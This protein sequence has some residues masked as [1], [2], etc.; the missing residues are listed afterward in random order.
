[1]SRTNTVP[2]PYSVCSFLN[3]RYTLSVIKHTAV[4]HLSA[5]R[6]R[7]VM[8]SAMFFLFSACVYTDFNRWHWRIR[9]DPSFLMSVKTTRLDFLYFLTDRCFSWNVNVDRNI[10]RLLF[11]LQRLWRW[12]VIDSWNSVASQEILQTSCVY[13]IQLPDSVLKYADGWRQS[14]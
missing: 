4:E 11:F 12:R 7:N 5:F 1:V 10:D 2:L 14:S 13:R 6:T 3:N 9:L 8:H